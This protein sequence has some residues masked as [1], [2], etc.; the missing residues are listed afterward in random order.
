MKKN[1]AIVFSLLLIVFLVAILILSGQKVKEKQKVST[2]AAGNGK[3]AVYL[4][5]DKTSLSPGETVAVS[6]WFRNTTSSDILQLN[7]GET[8]IVFDQ[9][10]FSAAF[11]G[12]NPCNQSFLY[13]AQKKT[14]TVGDVY[15]VCSLGGGDPLISLTPGQSLKLADF[16]LTVLANAGAGSTQLNFAKTNV[17][18]AG[19]PINLTDLSDAGTNMNLTVLGSNPTATPT[20]PVVATITPT[21]TQGVPSLTPE[22]TAT[23]TPEPSPTVPVATPTD[24]PNTFNSNILLKLKGVDQ[25]NLLDINNYRN[26]TNPRILYRIYKKGDPSD[27]VEV[28]TP[29]VYRLSDAVYAIYLDNVPDR[30]QTD[31]IILLKGEKHIRAKFCALNQTLRCSAIDELN[32]GINFTN[33]GTVD[34]TG[35]PLLPGDTNQ[36]GVLNGVDLGDMINNQ[37]VIAPPDRNLQF[38]LNYDGYVTGVDYGLMLNSMVVFDDE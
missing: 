29:A 9:A 27:F 34:L 11:A 31:A 22:P 7:V 13:N 5:S 8:D 6:V 38:D 14:I 16:N 18:D 17:P 2:R 4:L 30:F 19:D 12:N 32:G 20:T 23:V 1:I 25:T 10:V 21:V 28:N 15:I 35:Y 37:F 26:V 24:L 36:D 3:V 33:N